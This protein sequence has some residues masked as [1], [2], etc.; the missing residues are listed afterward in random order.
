MIEYKRGNLLDAQCDALVNTV[1]TVGIM[2]KG[3]ALQFKRAYPD[4]FKIYAQACKAEEVVPGR[5][6]VVS[7]G[8]LVGGPR[9]IIN[10][11]T[12]RHWRNASRLD[13]IEAGLQDLRRV[14]LELNIKS[15][16]IPPLGCGN[17]GLDW[18]EVRPAIETALADLDNV[19][20]HVYEPAGT[21][22]A[23]KMPN[24]TERPHMTRGRA[25]LLVLCRNY[26][27]PLLDTGITLLEVHKLMYFLQVAGEDL[28]LNFVKHHYG[29]YAN[30]LRHVLNHLEGHFIVGF[31]DGSENP[32]KELV[33]KD[34]AVEEAAAT[35]QKQADLRERIERVTD[36]IAGFEDSYGMELLATTHWVMSHDSACSASEEAAILAV[37]A[38]S[39]D[40]ARRLKPAH[41][42]TAWRW[43]KSRDWTC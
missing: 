31:G 32:G 37:Q 17:G 10:F 26:L 36:L 34:D 7:V 25:A 1:N 11:P 5:M 33:L 38:W 16:A 40:K 22:E 43:L 6:H 13:D 24:R 2:G 8:G 12:K 20:I 42:G 9:W 41:I 14:I 30:N 23:G 39:P 4:V 15:I 28:R 27:D 29:P 21:P 35:V 19:Q 3:I 18:R